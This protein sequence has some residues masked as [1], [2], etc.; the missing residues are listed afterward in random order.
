MSSA[1]AAWLH[2]DQ[3]TNL[4]VITGVLWFVE[5]PDWER[6][7]EVVRERLVERFPRFRQRVVEGTPPLS[8]PHWE[9]DPHFDLG[10]H[11][12]RIALAA[13][14]DRTALQALVADL[15]AAPLDR[16]APLWQF[17]LVDGYEG[18]AAI[19]VRIHH[20][21]ADGIALARVL[22]SLTDASPD[23]GL[24]PPGEAGSAA[25]VAR[26][27]LAAL[28]GPARSAASAAVGA[29]GAVAHES[30][31]VARHP[32]HLLDLAATTREDADVL[33]KV[34]LTGPDARTPLKGE[35]G[36]AKGVAWSAPVPLDEVRKMG[37]ETGTTINDVVVTAVAGALRRYL[38]AR[39]GLVDE[40]TVF[41]PFN[42]RPLDQ[43]LPSDLGN[44][45][46][47]VQLRLPVGI[48]DRR[49]RL[50]EVHARME[51]IKH[52][53]E[54]A[55]SYGLLDAVG[56]TPVQIE[57]RLIDLFSDRASAVVTN[58]PGPRRPVYLAGTQ[59]GGVLGLGTVLRGH[60]DDRLDLQ[61]CGSDHDRP[62]G[63]R[64]PRA[65]PRGDRQRLRARGPGPA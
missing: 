15:T 46:G 47:L 12:H 37:H 22:L 5:P 9:E 59:V 51:G 20:A 43:P 16:S 3:P 61:L 33:A 55:V 65:G 13:P 27:P 64:E 57:K 54:G 50:R 31:E 38:R 23:A 48:G 8:G 36:V 60:L 4:M 6:V 49:R 21:I 32:S 52:S 24:A 19:V 53:P 56:R 63:G 44:R 39:N 35:I 42:L 14:G 62:D 29:A 17:H 58:V 45:F 2:M 10:L 18:G 40:L 26:G 1:D 34:L 11:L 7:S 25:E 28:A 41:V 30:L